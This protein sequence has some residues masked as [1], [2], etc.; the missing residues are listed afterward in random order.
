MAPSFITLAALAEVLKDKADF[1]LRLTAA[2]KAND[3]TALAALAEECDALKNKVRALQ[4]AHR[5]SFHF[6]NK[7][8]GWELHDARYG[9]LAS[10]FETAKMRILAY[11]DGEIAAIEELEAPRLA[12]RGKAGEIGK[13]FTWLHCKSFAN[14]NFLS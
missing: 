9:G 11:L 1:G 12:L 2:Y 7:P 10:R 5:G 6:Y 8:F 13:S 3:K 14:P 4:E